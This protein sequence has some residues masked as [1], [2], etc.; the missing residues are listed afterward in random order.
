MKKNEFHDMIKA[1]YP[2]N[3][4]SD[5]QLEYLVSQAQFHKFAKNE[6]IFHEKESQ[7]E[8]DVYFLMSGTAKNVLHRPSGKQVSLRYYYPGDLVGLMILWTS[9]DMSFSVQAIEECTLFRFNKKVFFDMLTN[10]KEFS[11]IIFESVGNRMKTLYDEI[12]YKESQEESADLSLFRTKV[13]ILME[14]PVI[15]P[16]TS[17]MEEA[18]EKMLD[19]AAEAIVVCDDEGA[20]KGLVTQT[21][22]LRYLTSSRE[23]PT[24]EVWM[25]KNPYWVRDEAFAYEALSF[26]KYEGAKYVPV[27]RNGIV[28]GLLTGLSFV[29]IHDSSYLD[30]SYSIQSASST[31]DLVPLSPVE[32]T[33]FTSFIGGLLLQDSFAYNVSEVLTN[34]NDRLYRKIILLSEEE[35]RAE[36][37]GSPPVNYCFI[38]M[39]SQ[40]RGEQSF[41][42]D[43][44]NGIIIA[45]Y[46]HLDNA[47]AVDRY[48]ERFTEKINRKLAQCGFHECTGGIMAKEPKWRKSF[49]Q[50]KAAIDDWLH[51]IDAEEVQSFT[52]FYDFRPIFGDY[53]LAEDTRAYIAKKAQKSLNMQQL[54]RKDAIRFR[55]PINALGRINLKGRNKFFNIKKAGLMQIVNMVR[56]HSIKHGLKEVNTVQRLNA[57]KE[58]KVFHPRDAENAKTALHY[59]LYYRLNQN[60]LELE[61][62]RELTN[63]LEVEQLTKEDKRKLREALQIA[64]RMQQV[65]EISFNRNRVV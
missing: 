27:L 30:L 18:A 13:N 45:D 28:I 7:E 40:G 37:F 50:W 65:M 59:L 48:F 3:H 24:V 25:N 62:N 20:L 32:N 63:E 17:T 21:E 26:F 39:G 41:N 19:E 35:M 31:D 55:I 16:K 49:S 36:G 54:L 12:K 33:T 43:Q 9:G 6:F 15:L 57:L 5:E 56:I 64:N 42:T 10:N 23:A 60:L 51:E 52:M 53:S 58:L 44:D 22:I 2:F 29:N 34:Y 8:L 1:S 4:L 11:Q 61:E 47:K 14:S 46:D 38:V